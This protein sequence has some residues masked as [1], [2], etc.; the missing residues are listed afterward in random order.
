MKPFKK[1]LLSVLVIGILA[2]AAVYYY[3]FVYSK[4]NHRDVTKE[5]G[6]SKPVDS[7]FHEFQAN[8]QKWN[9]QYLNKA[10]ELSGRIKDVKQDS[11]TNLT[12]VGSDTLSSVNCALKQKNTSLKAGDIISVKGVCT[13]AMQDL[14]TNGTNIVINEAIIR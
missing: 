1:I 6:I 14:I 8:E 7:L 13:G 5:K 10:L 2:A 9:E 4:N 11:V 3:A 12:I